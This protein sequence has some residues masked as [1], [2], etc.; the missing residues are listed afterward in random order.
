MFECSFFI[1]ILDE[2]ADESQ[3]EAL[4]VIFGHHVFVVGSRLQA[5]HDALF[6]IAEI[7]QGTAQFRT[8][9]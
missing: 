4:P 2:E 7:L 6:R 1:S 9:P 3:S 8:E 5:A